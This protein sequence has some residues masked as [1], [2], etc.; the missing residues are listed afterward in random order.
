MAK[1]F[2]V[3]RL[4]VCLLL[5][6]LGTSAARSQSTPTAPDPEATRQLIDSLDRKFAQL[7]FQGDSLA[8]YSM[9]AKD[10]MLGNARGAEILHTISGWI[11]GSVKNN[12]R[13]IRY[14]TTSLMVDGGLIIEVGIAEVKD[15]QGQPKGKGKYLVVWKQEGQD[16]KLYRDIGL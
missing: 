1:F 13:H 2:P 16:W 8:L 15:D 12:A 5:V 11:T 4:A 10:A 7:Y 3:T 9:Y 14:H 6:I